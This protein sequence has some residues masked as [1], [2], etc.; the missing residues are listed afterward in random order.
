[1]SHEILDTLTS[2]KGPYKV[3]CKIGPNCKN[4]D[5]TIRSPLKKVCTRGPNCPN[6]DWDCSKSIRSSISI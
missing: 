4:H 6:H 3:V 2:R 1:M 5:W